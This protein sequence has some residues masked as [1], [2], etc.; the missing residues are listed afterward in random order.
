MIRASLLAT[1]A[2]LL[3][4]APAARA[5]SRLA[6]GHELVLTT[7]GEMA[8]SVAI[9]PN[10]HGQVRAE[11]G[12]DA[13][14]L[15]VTSG[16]RASIG[17]A[18]CPDDAGPLTIFVPA[19]TPVVLTA[20]GAGQVKLGDT[21]APLTVTTNGTGRLSVGRVSDLMLSQSG[22]GDV[23]IDR[24]TGPATVEIAG[25]GTVRMESVE[26]NLTGQIV[27]S[28]GL[29][30]GHIAAPRADI[31]MSGS[32]GALIGDGAIGK[33]AARSTGS[34]D[35]AVTA[36]VTDAVLSATGGGDMRLSRVT[37]TL[38][39][40]ASDG[41]TIEIGG[42]AIADAAI[43]VA[44]DAVSRANAMTNHVGNEQHHSNPGFHI[45]ILAVFGYLVYRTMKRYNRWP[46]R[47]AD[48]PQPSFLRRQG[49]SGP[50]AAYVARD[51]GL[52]ALNET[53]GRVE[54]RL[55]RMES[56]VT[57]REF[58]LHRQFRDLDSRS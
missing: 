16:D 21:A 45:F 30:V 8:V 4:A 10:L 34:G 43:G 31:T 51:P 53:L 33:L 19:N 29:I 56:F 47:L 1:A 37:G 55:G 26:A 20:S 11:L 5:E 35:M 50:Q 7:T 22:D 28:G 3:A 57:T 49:K 2:V 14:C 25:D 58:D 17:T 48:F 46:P 54:L 36:T 52:R 6:Q 12:G 15:S 44:A 27:G 24:V 13:A 39:K 32:G 18:G 41:S 23:H 42:S 40:Q 38:V 9:D